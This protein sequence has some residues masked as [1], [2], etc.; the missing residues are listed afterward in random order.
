MQTTIYCKNNFRKSI[1]KILKV[2]KTK[3]TFANLATARNVQLMVGIIIRVIMSSVVNVKITAPP[4][5]HVR[6]LDQHH[7]SWSPLSLLQCDNGQL[8]P[9]PHMMHWSVYQVR[10]YADH[11]GKQKIQNIITEIRPETIRKMSR[12]FKSCPSNPD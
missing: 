6:A 8:H 5:Q 10:Q 11:G 3:L 2:S 1:L 9:C 12:G 4:S 7:L